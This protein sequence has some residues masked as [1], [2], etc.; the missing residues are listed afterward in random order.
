MEIPEAGGLKRNIFMT[1]PIEYPIFIMTVKLDQQFEKKQK[2]AKKYG[3]VRCRT[4]I[5]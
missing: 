5:G 3:H 4:V 1:S 2:C